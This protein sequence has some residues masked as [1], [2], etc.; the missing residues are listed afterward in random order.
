MAKSVI[1]RKQGGENGQTDPLD[2]RI[3]VEDELR[4]ERAVSSSD[5]QTEGLGK[6]G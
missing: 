1:H 5:P 3:Q 2:G 6:H 4:R